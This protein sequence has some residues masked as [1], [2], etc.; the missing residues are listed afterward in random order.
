LEPQ[1]F[2]AIACGG[3][4]GGC[5]AVADSIGGRQLIEHGSAERAPLLQSRYDLA[6]PSHTNV[7]VVDRNEVVARF[8]LDT[9]RVRVRMYV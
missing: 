4:G 9:S 7:E 3:S 6:V 8:H 2:Q 1:S 5:T